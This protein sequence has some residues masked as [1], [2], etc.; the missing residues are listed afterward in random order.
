MSPSVA[1]VALS[2]AFLVAHAFPPATLLMIAGGLEQRTA[3][4]ET[5]VTSAVEFVMPNATT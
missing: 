3:D 4:L 5:R 2:E 1:A